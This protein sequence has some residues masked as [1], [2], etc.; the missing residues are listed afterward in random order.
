[1]VTVFVGNQVRAQLFPLSRFALF[2]SKQQG[3]L[4]QFNALLFVRTFKS[5]SHMVCR[6]I[7][8]NSCWAIPNN[9]LV[10]RYNRQEREHI[11]LA[12]PGQILT[13]CFF[14]VDYSPFMLE[15]QL[16]TVLVGLD[17]SLTYSPSWN[18]G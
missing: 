10:T 12:Y 11:P 4:F 13:A 18:L 9:F 3:V 17:I 2:L 5:A 6:K 16:H 15:K 7:C 8:Q 14:H 1:M